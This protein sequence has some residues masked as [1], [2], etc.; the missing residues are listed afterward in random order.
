MEKAKSLLVN[1][2]LYSYVQLLFSAAIKTGHYEPGD[3]NQF[4]ESIIWK[5]LT[6]EGLISAGRMNPEVLNDIP[7]MVVTSKSE[8]FSEN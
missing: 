7:S 6:L 1:E 5:G 4:I 2:E 3:W 8:M